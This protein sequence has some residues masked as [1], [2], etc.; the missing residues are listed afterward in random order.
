MVGALGFEPRV[1]RTRNVN[2]TVT[3]CPGKNA[4]NL[5]CGRYRDRTCYLS[6]VKTALYQVS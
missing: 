5:Q 6:H 1:L 3:L 2:V 4:C